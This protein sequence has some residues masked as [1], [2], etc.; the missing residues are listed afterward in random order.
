MT[1]AEERLIGSCD[2]CVHCRLI[3][4]Q[5]VALCTHE[6]FGPGGHSI[7][8]GH[9]IQKIIPGWCPQPKITDS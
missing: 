6:N 4:A 9:F 2:E 1:E 5:R 7:P 8:D 3:L